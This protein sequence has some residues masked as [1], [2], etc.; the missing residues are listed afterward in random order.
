MPSMDDCG[1]AL[2]A[3]QSGMPRSPDAPD[4]WM[5]AGTFFYCDVCVGTIAL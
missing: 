5:N 3:L 1:P 4:E 2:A